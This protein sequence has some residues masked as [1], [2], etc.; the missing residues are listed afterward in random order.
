MNHLKAGARG[1]IEPDRGAVGIG[2]SVPLLGPIKR[3]Q[4]LRMSDSWCGWCNEHKN[5]NGGSPAASTTAMPTSDRP[6]ARHVFQAMISMNRLLLL[7]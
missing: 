3:N 6:G 4:A 7:H 2:T 1:G 5:R